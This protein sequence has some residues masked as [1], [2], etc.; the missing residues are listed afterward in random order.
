M[1]ILT[2]TTLGRAAPDPLLAKWPGLHVLIILPDSGADPFIVQK[3]QNDFIIIEWLQPPKNSAVLLSDVFGW[4]KNRLGMDS[5]PLLFLDQPRMNDA[6]P[7]LDDSLSSFAVKADFGPDSR[8]SRLALGEMIATSPLL[9]D[10]LQMLSTR[11]V[12]DKTLIDLIATELAWE[13]A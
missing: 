4:L 6:L 8:L 10:F 3:Y 13:N 12:D 5:G 9:P 7:V 1:L 2:N 11:D